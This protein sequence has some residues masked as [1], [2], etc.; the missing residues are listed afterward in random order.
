MRTKVD[1]NCLIIDDKT[2][3][4]FEYPIE[5]LTIIGNI[6]IVILSIPNSGGM[7]ENVFGVSNTGNILWQIER[8]TANA[9][10]PV[11]R[12]VGFGS[13]EMNTLFISNWNGVVVQIDVRT[14]Q[15]LKSEWLK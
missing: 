7:T 8:L 6:I 9:T 4:P 3:V 13:H 10:D 15:V 11:N 5:A 14:G 12:Y 1:T 2:V